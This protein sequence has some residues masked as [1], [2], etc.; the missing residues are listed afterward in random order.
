MA[1][2]GEA[3]SFDSEVSKENEFQ[4]IPNGDYQFVV[5]SY[6]RTQFDGS[7]KMC[8]CPEVDVVLSVKYQENGEEK[9]RDVTYKIFLNKKVEGRISEFFEGIGMKKKSEPFRM[10]WNEIVGK[11]GKLKMGSRTY[12]GTDFN[13]I[14][15]FYPK[16][17][18]ASSWKAGF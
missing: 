18:S 17:M 6:E 13:D 11:S 15:K 12:Q 14:K 5:V 3:L 9:S 4:L 10:A 16:D 1:D 7:E 2:L 8:A